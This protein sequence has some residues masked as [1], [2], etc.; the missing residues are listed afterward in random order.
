M[1]SKLHP[2]SVP[3]RGGGRA[4]GGAV[5]GS[6]LGSMAQEPLRAMSL[7][8][9]WLPLG[10]VL[11]A[12]LGVGAIVYET[13]RYRVF[14]Y[15][16]DD[17]TLNIDSGVLFRRERE[18]PLG[19]IQ[20]VDMTRS[21]LQRFLG[22]TGVDIE[23]AGGRSTEASLEYVS[24]PEAKR[25]QE[26]I[27]TRKRTIEQDVGTA[28]V[29]NEKSSDYERDPE[30]VLFELDDE[31]LIL[32]SILSFDPRALTVLFIILPTVSPFLS[33]YFEGR[34]TIALGIIGLVLVVLSAIGIWVMSAFTRFVNYYGF[35]LTRVGEELRYERGLLQRYDGSIPEDKI[36]TIRIEENVLMRLFDYASLSI[37]TAG[38][39]P[40]AETGSESAVPLA[41]ESDLKALAREVEDFGDLTFERPPSKAR[42]RYIARYA[43]AVTAVL[44]VGFA[45]SRIV[46]PIPWY[47]LALLYGAVPIAA[48]K[49]W[50]HRG[51]DL[52]D[53]YIAT[54][55]GFWR[56]Q[57]H[58]VPNDRVQTV[59][60]S[61]TIFQRRWRLGTVVVD[62]ASSGS[63]VSS[64]A[65]AIDIDTDRAESLRETVAA[66]LLSSLGIGSA[67][68][69]GSR[70]V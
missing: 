45:A 33:P 65:R 34:G 56:R 23:T 62:T 57:T 30:T 13:L 52:P 36:Q 6:V 11:A 68:S 46:A 40:S 51:W 5:G 31:S 18:I 20:N 21:I 59:I 3:I 64:E 26:G 67:D 19:R 12:I 8:P 2:L 53:G 14:A 49:T 4:L 54:R 70:K 44:G 37:E 28:D 17:T 41:T 48:H 24:H 27:R 1:A 47:L 22:I 63:F 69:E 60:D 10:L 43:I 16:L 66:R 25:L 35:T 55:S 39:G 42:R 38:Y 15:E 58:V 7:A 50:A 9:R 29:D 61:R 32:Y